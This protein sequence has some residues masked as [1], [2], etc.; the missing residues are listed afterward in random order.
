MPLHAGVA[1]DMVP[2]SGAAHPVL[3]GD[4][5][6]LHSAFRSLG[7]AQLGSSSLYGCLQ[8]CCPIFLPSTAGLLEAH[9]VLCA[10]KTF[11]YER[12]Q[13]K[14][15]YKRVPQWQFGRKICVLR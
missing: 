15:S 7:R 9:F 11:F 13:V 1:S 5:C 6:P 2:Q 4:F 3:P 8:G 14:Q 12:W 10:A